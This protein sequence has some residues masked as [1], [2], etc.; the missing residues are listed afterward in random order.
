MYM[1]INY[2]YVCVCVCIH[3]YIVFLNDLQYGVLK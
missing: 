2:I 1:Y 3:G